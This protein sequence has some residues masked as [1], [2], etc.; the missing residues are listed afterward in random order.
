[1]AAELLWNGGVDLR[2][3]DE[4]SGEEEKRRTTD[5]EP[6]TVVMEVGMLTCA[7]GESRSD[8]RS[9]TTPSREGEAEGLVL[10]GAPGQTRL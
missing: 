5:A 9:P 3:H 2:G 6:W 8:G 7:P 10:A 1:M 4:G